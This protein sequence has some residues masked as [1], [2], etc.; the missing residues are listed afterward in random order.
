MTDYQAISQYSVNFT[1]EFLHTLNKEL[2]MRMSTVFARLVPKPLTDARSTS[3]SASVLTICT[4][5]KEIL[6]TFWTGLWLWTNL[7]TH[8]W[9]KA[10]AKAMEALWLAPSKGQ[11]CPVCRE[12]HGII[13]VVGLFF[14]WGGGMP[15]EF[16]WYIFSERVI[17]WLDNTM[18]PCCGSCRTMLLL[19]ASES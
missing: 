19:S 16:Y 8:A 15:L 1:P 2:A 14:F 9:N 13:F 17:Q 18:W 7:W 6:P 12:T 3:N 10:T 11:D 4:N 5:L